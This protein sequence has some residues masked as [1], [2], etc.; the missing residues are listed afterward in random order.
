MGNMKC[1]LLSNTSH[2]YRHAQNHASSPGG[3]R[4]R[5]APPPHQKRWCQQSLVGCNCHGSGHFCRSLSMVCYCKLGFSYTP[6][7]SRSLTY[8]L[9][10]QLPLRGHRRAPK[11]SSYRV[12]G[13]PG[14]HRILRVYNIRFRLELPKGREDVP[15]GQR[16]Q[17]LVL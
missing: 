2:A 8:D 3:P 5:L 11:T 17:S 10:V 7:M 13:S 1:C 15:P 6:S 12:A 16:H 14:F 9:A 4:D